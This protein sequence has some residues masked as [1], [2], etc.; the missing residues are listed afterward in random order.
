MSSLIA[1]FRTCLV[2]KRWCGASREKPNEGRCSGEIVNDWRSRDASEYQPRARPGGVRSKSLRGAK[3]EVGVSFSPDG[4]VSE[5]SNSMKERDQA[6]NDL[7]VKMDGHV[8]LWLLGLSKVQNQTINIAVIYHWRPN[9][10]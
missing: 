8:V 7:E 9:V 1:W 6:K 5:R 4:R 10:G 2:G 3:S